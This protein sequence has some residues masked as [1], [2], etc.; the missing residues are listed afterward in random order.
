MYA[1]MLKCTPPHAHKDAHTEITNN[2]N[3]NNCD[4]KM[5]W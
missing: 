1:Y 5:E 4:E 3:N 2:N